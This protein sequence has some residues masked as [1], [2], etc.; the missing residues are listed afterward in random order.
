MQPEIPPTYEET[1][2]GSKAMMAD[3][4]SRIKRASNWR[5]LQYILL[6]DVGLSLDDKCKAMENAVNIP[7]ITEEKDTVSLEDALWLQ[8]SHKLAQSVCYYY[9]IA[10]TSADR[11]WCKALIEAD[12]E[13]RWIV[14]RMIW[15]HHQLQVVAYRKAAFEEALKALSPKVGR[16]HED[17]QGKERTSTGIS[18]RS[19]AKTA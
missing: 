17:S 7:A 14:Q 11:S 12:I 9:H 13:I 15:I 10:C 2:Q 19:Y 16:Q 8:G 4:I 18:Q 1:T 6:A 3:F 5:S